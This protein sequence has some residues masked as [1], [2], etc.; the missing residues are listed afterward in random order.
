MY[1]V[2]GAVLVTHERS[3]I[4]VT[5]LVWFVAELFSL[6]MNQ[7]TS[8]I[9][10]FSVFGENK[11]DIFSIRDHDKNVLIFQRKNMDYIH[12]RHNPHHS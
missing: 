1:A 7:V 10:F 12:E 5:I 11:F 9:R 2:H 4:A 3:K 8:C 6:P